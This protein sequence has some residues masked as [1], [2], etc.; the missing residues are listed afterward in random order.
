MVLLRAGLSERGY[1]R[2]GNIVWLENV[3]PTSSDLD[4]RY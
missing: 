1:S 2:V 4:S 3:C